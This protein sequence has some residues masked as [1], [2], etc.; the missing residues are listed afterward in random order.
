MGPSGDGWCGAGWGGPGSSSVQGSKQLTWSLPVSSVAL[1]GARALWVS[2]WPPLAPPS[3]WLRQN[4]TKIQ[5]DSLLVACDTFC[6]CGEALS[7]TERSAPYSAS[8]RP[9][10]VPRFD[11]WKVWNAPT[12]GQNV[13]P[14]T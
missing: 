10:G 4:Y 14:R 9:P 7:V 5:K 3:R 8:T 6:E 11:W 2:A 12:P 13:Q 1:Q